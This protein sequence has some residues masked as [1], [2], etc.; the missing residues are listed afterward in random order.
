MQLTD[1]ESFITS[2]PFNGRLGPH[3]KNFAT[4]G[5]FGSKFVG[6]R[7]CKYDLVAEAFWGRIMYVV[8]RVPI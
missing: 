1:G 5:S 7:I 8:V 3:Y 6:I 4:T 2:T